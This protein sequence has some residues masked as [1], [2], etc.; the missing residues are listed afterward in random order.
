MF[1]A[2]FICF[3]MLKDKNIIVSF[4][5]STLNKNVYDSLIK[6]KRTTF[7][8]AGK[9]LKAQ[10]LM[11]FTTFLLLLIGFFILNVEYALLLAFLISLVDAI[12]ILGTG[13]ILIPWAVISLISKKS[14]LG[15][16]L[17]SLYG[18]CALT[19][20]IAEPKIIGNKL[21]IHPLISIIS[22]YVG[23]QLFGLWGLI[24]GPIS[25]VLLKNLLPAKNFR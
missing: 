13:T 14:A 2:F 19:R 25:A 3:F 23:V 15:W 8:V 11:V 12:P 20:Q 6:A 10:L 7:S 5:K 4:L 17:L 21:G 9:Y 22:I 16:G 24:I 1:T 18:V